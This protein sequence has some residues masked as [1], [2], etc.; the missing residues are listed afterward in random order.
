MMIAVLLAVALAW[1]LHRRGELLPNLVRLGGAAAAGLIALRL[2]QSGRPVMALVAGGIGYAW[3]RLNRP[4]PASGMAE[5]EALALLGLKPG[6]GEQAI[7][8]AWRAAMQGAHPD[9]GGSDEA[10]R[11]V[12]AA[13]DLLLARNKMSSEA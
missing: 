11:A 12:T 10:A 1:W 9:A 8:L 13:R 4:R 7:H 2:L 3:W 5:A 6:A